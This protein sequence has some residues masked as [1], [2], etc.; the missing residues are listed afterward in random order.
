MRRAA[1]LSVLLA[2]CGGKVAVD[3]D[4]PNQ[5]PL[6][7][8]AC[9]ALVARDC[10]GSDCADRC[11][12]V[13]SSGE[14]AAEVSALLGCLRDQASAAA[15][16]V[17][18]ACVPQ[19]DALQTCRVGT[20]CE[21]PI[22]SQEGPDQIVGKGLCASVVEHAAMCDGSLQCACIVDVATIAMCTETGP[23]LAD[24]SGG[25]CAA[26]FPQEG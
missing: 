18:E 15:S 20:S 23:F 3:A 12:E 1:L 19:R 24:I 4:G 16:C 8:D 13:A 10:G 25:C 14:C 6:C 2:A 11:N 17:I 7:K 5:N 22:L 9:A 21:S 26:S